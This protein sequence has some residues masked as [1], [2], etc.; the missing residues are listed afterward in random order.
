MSKKK[1]QLNLTAVRKMGKD[2]KE[3]KEVHFE[4]YTFKLDV[5]F[6]EYKL[7]NLYQDLLNTTFE[8]NKEG[9]DPY[10]TKNISILMG[11]YHV[12]IVKNFTNIPFPEKCSLKELLSIE[13]DLLNTGLL[14]F[15]L[16]NF[17]PEELE[18][19]LR[20]LEMGA[21]NLNEMLQSVLNEE[22][23]DEVEEVENESK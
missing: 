19:S 8:L 12:L 13:E 11:I 17:D 15:I 6:S 9:V 2:F 3:Q 21:S 5:K 20:Y 18:K 4:E 23:D 22:G 10:D 16:S 7:K 14:K 1:K